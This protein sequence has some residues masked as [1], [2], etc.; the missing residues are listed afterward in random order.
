MIKPKKIICID[1]DG[2]IH[3]Y[4]SGWQ[5]IDVIEDEPVPG[6]FGFLAACVGDPDLQPV[7]YSSRSREPKGID[8]MI[9]WFEKHKMDPCILEEL[10]F[11]NKKPSAWLTI[12][13]RAFCF[14]GKFPDDLEIKDFKPWYRKP[15][16]DPNRWTLGE[17]GMELSEYYEH[18]LHLLAL[19]YADGWYRTRNDKGEYDRNLSIDKGKFHFMIP[20]WFDVGNLEEIYFRTIPYRIKWETVLRKRG[21]AFH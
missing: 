18:L 13:D 12:D 19:N 20:D 8:A 3:S 11:A 15:H 1:F 14:N 2:V 9:K 21:I 5:G 16:M 6:A 4:T 7:I 10:E 17:K